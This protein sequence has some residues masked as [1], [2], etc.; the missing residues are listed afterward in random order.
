MYTIVHMLMF[1]VYIGVHLLIVMYLALIRI[2]S[3][4]HSFISFYSNRIE[5]AYQEVLTLK[6]QE[7]LIRFVRKMRF[8]KLRVSKK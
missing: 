7:E 3:P 6:R 2:L 5:V 4:T 1:S 8:G